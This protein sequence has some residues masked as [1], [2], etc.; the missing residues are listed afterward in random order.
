[1]SPSEDMRTSSTAVIDG[2]KIVGVEADNYKESPSRNGAR[3][4]AHHDP[5]SRGGPQHHH[6]S[7]SE[8]QHEPPPGAPRLPLS[9]VLITLNAASQL[10]ACLASLAFADEIVVVD[11]GSTDA[12]MDIARRHGARVITKEW[13]GF[14]AQKQFAV[15]QA[16]HDWVLCVDADERVTP[17]LQA[18]I[19]K[20][21]GV[22]YSADNSA[23]RMAR[24]NVFMGRV[25]R[26]GEGYP[27]WNLRLFDRRQARWSD[28]PVHENVV[29]SAETSIGTLDGDLMHESS[30]SLSI[31]VAKQN[32][33]TDLQAAR[34]FEQ[35]QHASALRIAVAPLVRFIK[36]YF[37]RLGFL[38][39]IPGLV[40]ILIGC[41]NSRLKYAKLRELERGK[42]DHQ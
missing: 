38:D 30:E 36:F 39:G 2:A 20:T 25:L 14:G 8:P 23:W 9:A 26:H 40:H 6:G 16:A 21:L 32:R 1:M 33:Y 24:A 18:S 11:A 37:F 15:E 28:D 27:D 5:E 29:P 22:S 19:A 3:S 35:G 4:G 17:A 13:L 12:T 42:P 41:Q 7:R 10:E 34:L 31:Y